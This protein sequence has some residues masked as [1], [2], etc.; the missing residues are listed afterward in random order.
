MNKATFYG[1]YCIIFSG[2]LQGKQIW[3]ILIFGILTLVVLACKEDIQEQPPWISFKK[4]DKYSKSG[5]TI[6]VGHP[7]LFGIQARSD[8][9]YL[10]NFTIRKKMK[11]GSQEV[12][13]DTALYSKYLDIDK[14]FYQNIEPE[15]DWVFTVMDRN[16]MFA[17]IQMRIFK[18]VHSVYGGIYYFPSIK[19][20]FQKNTL[21]GHFLNP[22]SGLTYLSDSVHL[23]QNDIDILCYFK[24]DEVP[25]GPV[26]SSPGE[27]DNYSTDAQ[28]FYPTIE[29]WN[30]RKYTLWDISI[31]N[32]PLS[33]AD[34]ESAHNDSL[35]IV[36]YNP[37]WGKKKYKWA[38]AGKIIPF[39]TATGKH[40]LVRVLY[41]DNSDQGM[42]EIAVKIQR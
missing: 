28:T 21:Y 3:R 9:S 2:S 8:D 35:L 37:V 14:I 25:P 10:T 16:R 29:Q 18:D 41:S 26:L 32:T 23:Y 1:K 40:G 20:G 22:S 6:A 11:D 42:M 7:L 33:L 31:D 4:G 39:Q 30:T 12:V 27:M 15:V 24:N 17:T 36:S 38:S 5:D 13:M 19:L 34:F